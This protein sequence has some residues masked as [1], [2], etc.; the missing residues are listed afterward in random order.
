M[1]KRMETMSSKERQEVI[2][3]FRRNDEEEIRLAKRNQPK[4]PV[5]ELPVPP[6]KNIPETIKRPSTA[7]NEY[8]KRANPLDNYV[9]EVYSSAMKTKISPAAAVLEKEAKARDLNPED[10]KRLTDWANNVAEIESNNIPDRKQGDDPEGIGRGKYQFEIRSKEGQAAAKTA[11]NRFFE[12]EKQNNI[13]LD[14]PK[15]DREELKKETPDFSVLAEETQDA[16]FFI[17]HI[18]H[19][20]T[21][22][23]RIAKGTYDPKKAWANF[24]YAGPDKKDRE[25]M[26][27]SRIEGKGFKARLA[28]L[29]NTFVDA[30]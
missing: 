26:W 27:E 5:D 18:L 16:A 10:V 1:L 29:A 4:M 8:I 25:R 22:L 14:I 2:D 13:T 7:P 20:R 17:N 6:S 30:I 9:E 28:S 11:A 21:P 12:W 3:Y 19:P 23:T 15:K 24:H